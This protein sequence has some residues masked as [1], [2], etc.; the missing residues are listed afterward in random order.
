MMRFGIVQSL[1][2]DIHLEHSDLNVVEWYLKKPKLRKERTFVIYFPNGK[3]KKIRGYDIKHAL[4]T[5]GYEA[6]KDFFI[7]HY[8]EVV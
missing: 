5:N 4:Y 1:E 2:L 3:E 6:Y 8:D 7:N